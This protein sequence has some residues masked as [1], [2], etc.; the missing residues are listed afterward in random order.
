VTSAPRL[1]KPGFDRTSGSGALSDR[2][3]I[4]LDRVILSPRHG[5]VAG[6]ERT[7]LDASE[8]YLRAYPVMAL[9]FAIANAPLVA[10]AEAGRAGGSLPAARRAARRALARAVAARARAARQAAARA[11]RRLRGARRIVTLSRSGIVTDALGRLA[12]R[13]APE[14]LVAESLPAREGLVTAR[15]LVRRGIGVTV[16]PDALLA[17][18]A[19]GADAVLVGAD[20]LCE[21]GFVNKSGTLAL[22]LGARVSRTPVIV[23]AESMKR[24]SSA[25]PLFLPPQRASDPRGGARRPRRRVARLRNP[26]RGGGSGV[27]GPAGNPARVRTW[28]PIFEWVP[29]GEET[30]VVTDGTAAP[31]NVRLHGGLIRILD[32]RA[33]ASMRHS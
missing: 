33:R 1:P 22:T 10:V 8:P 18:A 21:D 7:L 25:V 14:I 6:L 9:L 3:A 32:R 2:L 4:A 23:A 15:A 24:L 13:R 27:R 16:F 26:A 31:T 20:R 5:S 28:S 12:G 11:A 29:Y 19:A 17:A 30:V